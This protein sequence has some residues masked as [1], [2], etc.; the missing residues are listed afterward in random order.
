MPRKQLEARLGQ[1][2]AGDWMSLL[3]ESAQCAQKAHTNSVRLRRRSQPDEAQRAARTL[4]LVQV[5]ELSTARQAL[6]GTALAPGQLV[7]LHTLTDP[8]RRPLVPRSGIE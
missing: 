6:E 2:Q 7:T 8:Q 5:A 1:F 4:S 3:N